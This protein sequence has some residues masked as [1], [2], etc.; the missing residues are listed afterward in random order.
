MDKDLSLTEKIDK[1]IEKLEEARTKKRFKLP[2]SIRLQKGKIKRKNYCVVV[3]I[4]TNGA[5]S[6]R[7]LPI[8][9]DTVKVGETFHDARAG[10]ILRY[11][12]Y[13]LLIVPEWNMKPIAPDSDEIKTEPFNPDK[14]FKEAGENGTL[15]SA[16]KLI[17]TKMKLEAIKPKM[18]INIGTILIIG[19]VLVGGYFLLDYLKII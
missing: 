7:M 17:L 8:E 13:P 3:I 6:I 11:K 16:Q 5:V 18:K 9:E 10:N 19:A 12:N 15:T 14:D 1:V 2:L 4:R